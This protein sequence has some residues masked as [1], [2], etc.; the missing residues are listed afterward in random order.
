M[1]G[2]LAAASVLLAQPSEPEV[3][4]SGGEGRSIRESVEGLVWGPVSS[5]Y[6]PGGISLSLIAKGELTASGPESDFQFRI[7]TSSPVFVRGTFYDGVAV[8]E[9]CE[10]TEADYLVLPFASFCRHEPIFRDAVITLIALGYARVQFVGENGLWDVD[11]NEAGISRESIL[12]FAEE[13]AVLTAT[14][15]AN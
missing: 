6:L 3:Y 10:S 7:W 15:G 9:N 2:L 13:A 12:T 11:L 1:I 5:N 4:I 8:I 14:H